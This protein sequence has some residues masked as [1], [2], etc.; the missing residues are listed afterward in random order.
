MDQLSPPEVL[1]LDGNIA[2]NWR[3]WKQRF[4][5]FSLASGP[6][7]KDTKVQAATFL[8]KTGL[9]ALEVYNTFAWDSND[10]KSK[11]DKSLKNLMNIATLARTLRGNAT[12]SA[13]KTSNQE[14][15][16]IDMLLT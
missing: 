7:R 10:D 12:Y 13:C 5:I 4:G 3:Q 14:K 16:S 1:S 11:V 6:S 15:A 9:E 2:E 8:H